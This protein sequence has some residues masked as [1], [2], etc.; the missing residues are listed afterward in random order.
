MVSHIVMYWF[1]SEEKVAQAE[2]ALLSMRGKIEGMEELTVGR[3]FMHSPRSCQL[4]L[5]ERFVSREALAAYVEHPVHL[6]VKAL[7]HSIVSRS[8]SA[9]FE[10]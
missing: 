8:C 4:C 2:K 3:D 6:P 10:L 9:D 7:M 1:D 5:C